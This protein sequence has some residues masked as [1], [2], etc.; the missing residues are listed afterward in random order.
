M[1]STKKR[2]TGTLP[3][4][5]AAPVETWDDSFL[6]TLADLDPRRFFLESWRVLDEEAAAERRA[7]E[8]RKA[9]R[10]WR[11]LI[12]LVVGALTLTAMEYFGHRPTFQKLLDSLIESNGEQ[13]IWAQARDSQFF[14]LFTF[15]YWSGWRVLGYFLVPALVVK[16]AF[17]SPLHEFGLRGKGFSKHLWV[18][19]VF[20]CVVLLC[21]VAVSY[22]RMFQ[23]HYPFYDQASRSWADLAMWECLY[24]AQFFSLE[25]FFRGFWL[26]ACKTQ[27]GSGAVLAMI[28]PYCMIHYGKPLPE[29]LGAIFAG[30]ALGTLAMRTRSIWG[31][32]LI[33]VGIA[34]SMDVAALLQTT[35]LPHVWWP[36]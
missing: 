27:M 31:G 25:F 24:A 6:T 36:R 17:K 28:V 3:P 1:A 29:T 19:G 8:E 33:H 12:A 23:Q 14:E 22:T 21:V 10:D 30:L 11:P 26:R 5:P 35:G 4:R 15:V 16:F 32:I 34:V 7:R 13:S 2:P 18:Y 9:G 20:Y